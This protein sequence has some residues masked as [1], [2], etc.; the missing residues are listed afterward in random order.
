MAELQDKVILITGATRGIGQASA[1]ICA[2]E[3]AKVI[4]SSIEAERADQ[5]AG[6]LPGGPQRHAGLLLDVTD[7]DHRQRAFDFIHERFGRLDGLVNNAGIYFSKAFHETERNEW[8]RVMEMDLNA[9][10]DLSQHAIKLFLESGGGAIVNIS[11]VHTQATYH[12][13]VAYAAA[14]GAVTMLTKGLAVEYSSKNIRVNAIAPGLI[15][16]E[17]WKSVVEGFASEEAAL[18]YWNKNIPL[19]DIILP[20]AIGEVVSF[21]LSE[22]ARAMSG[23]IVFADGG[24]TSQLVADL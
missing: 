13:S 10:Y 17:I 19:G 4:L 1:E 8:D 5:L 2:R 21:L 18:A 11:S 23:S 9:V 14:K 16:T 15:K 7:P 24:M 22:R 12:G 3:G 6:A 20:D